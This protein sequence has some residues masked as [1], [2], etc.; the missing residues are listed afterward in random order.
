MKRHDDREYCIFSQLI[1]IQLH[2]CIKNMAMSILTLQI[3][4]IKVLWN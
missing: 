3:V 2:F 4:K 1:L